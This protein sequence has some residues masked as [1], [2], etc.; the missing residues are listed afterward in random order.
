VAEALDI[1]EDADTLLKIDCIRLDEVD[2][3]S[4]FKKNIFHDGKLLFQKT[5]ENKTAS[6]LK[7]NFDNLGR[8]LEAERSS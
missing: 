2:S 5:G 1:I 6:R 3:N 4:P 7:R 8:V